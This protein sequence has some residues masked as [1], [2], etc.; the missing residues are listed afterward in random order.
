[1]K[2][3]T[4][5]IGALKETA[6]NA[7]FVEG[8]WLSKEYKDKFIVEAVKALTQTTEQERQFNKQFAKKYSWDNVGKQWNELFFGKPVDIK[9]YE[10]LI[11]RA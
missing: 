11:D 6:C 10:P 4:S 3:V 7:V 1:M 5:P 9:K 8:D 2:L